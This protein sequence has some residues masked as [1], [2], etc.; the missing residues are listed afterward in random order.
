M[1]AYKKT[2][3]LAQNLKMRNRKKWLNMLQPSFI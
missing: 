1:L 3:Y 2:V